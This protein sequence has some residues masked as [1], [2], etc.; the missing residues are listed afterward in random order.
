MNIQ[1]A[2]TMRELRASKQNTQEQLAS[3]LGVT[4]QAVSK[5]ERGEGYPDIALLPSI[6]S[7][8]GVS[9]DHLLGVDETVKAEKLANYRTKSQSNT[10][11]TAE[12]L[13]IWRE[14]YAEFPNEPSVLHALAWALRRDNL[15]DNADEIQKLSERLLKEATQSGEYFGA[16]NNLCR[17]HALK[18]DMDTAKKY[19]SMA[20][21]YIGTENQLMIRILEGDEAASFCHWNIQTLTD[22]IADNADVMLKKGTFTNEEQ[23]STVK[24]IVDLFDLMFADEDCS[25]YRMRA[26]TWAMKLA[27]CYAQTENAEETLRLVEQAWRHAEAY[28]KFLSDGNTVSKESLPQLAVQNHLKEKVKKDLEKPCFAFLGTAK[29]RFREGG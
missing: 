4:V 24:R 7:F 13:K 3:H 9:V 15:A 26:C 11:T 23:L 20:G 2:K 21:R 10:M 16:I 22:L 25:L 28:D 12:R 17:I 27:A 29:D 8:Y 19:A 6:A 14:A 1:I 18:G 5:W